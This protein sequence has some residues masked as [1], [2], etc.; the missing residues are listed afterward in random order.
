MR[1]NAVLEAKVRPRWCG[2][3]RGC[4]AVSALRR[5]EAR[6][7]AG[8]DMLTCPGPEDRR[9]RPAA[10]RAGRGGD[11]LVIGDSPGCDLPV[12]QRWNRVSARSHAPGSPPCPRLRGRALTTCLRCEGRRHDGLGS[13]SAVDPRPG[14][15]QARGV[16]L[17]VASA[18]GGRRRCVGKHR[19][20]SLSGMVN[21][22]LPAVKLSAGRASV[23]G[24]CP[25]AATE[26]LA[27]GARLW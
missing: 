11:V 8:S 22:G 26:L 3:S 13:W 14:G 2:G 4:P 10:G 24:V 17:A 27:T 21:P 16:S 5:P 15:P 6:L 19:V 9:L 23:D 25:H 12:P 20:I 18:P 7:G 1:D